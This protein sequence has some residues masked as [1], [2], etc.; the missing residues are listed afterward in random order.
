MDPKDK[1]GNKNPNEQQKDRGA[2]PGKQQDQKRDQGRQ[3]QGQQPQGQ[4][5]QQPQGQR[6]QGQP[7]QGQQPQGQKP[8]GQEQNKPTDWKKDQQSDKDI[9]TGRTDERK[10]A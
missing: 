1:S 10:R 4:H 8:Q 6:P 9:D 2:Q 5:G 3:S 7:P